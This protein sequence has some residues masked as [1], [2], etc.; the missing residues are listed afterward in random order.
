MK[1][2]H[3]PGPWFTLDTGLDVFA[4]YPAEPDYLP[5]RRHIAA[6]ITT[7]QF[8]QE[9][10]ANACLIAAAP[11]MLEQLHLAERNVSWLVS[12]LSAQH[13]RDFLGVVPEN[14]LAELRKVIAEAK[15]G[16]Q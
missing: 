5:R 13:K 6:A 11:D 7:C 3:T 8:D 2:N 10:R 16:A 9:S 4:E 15:G 14:W 12:N 1:T